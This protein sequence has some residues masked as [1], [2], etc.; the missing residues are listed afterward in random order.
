MSKSNDVTA[1]I[2]AVETNGLDITIINRIDNSAEKRANLLT[3]LLAYKAAIGGHM[4]VDAAI[5]SKIK[6]VWKPTS[7]TDL[8]TAGHDFGYP[9][10]YDEL[11][12]MVQ[13]KALAK[14]KTHDEDA[15]IK[16]LTDG[17]Y[18]IENND[19]GNY[20][21]GKKDNIVAKNSKFFLTRYGVQD[22]K[23]P[24]ETWR[25]TAMKSRELLSMF[26]KK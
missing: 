21:T 7:A 20:T 19:W 3:K 26:F 10:T 1:I 8:I 6:Y 2:A 18:S 14:L 13:N 16:Y 11:T 9:V 24:A 5:V 12:T 17:D 22:K 4:G 25:Y 15:Y 23:T